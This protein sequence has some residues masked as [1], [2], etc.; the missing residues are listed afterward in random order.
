[1]SKNEEEEYS[2]Q[3]EVVEE[4]QEAIAAAFEQPR[5]LKSEESAN[6]YKQKADQYYDQLLRLQAEFANYR[7]RIEKEKVEAI[8]F[9]KEM[10]VERMISLMDVMEE[11]LKHSQNA[12]AI[13]SLKKGFEMV[14][15]EFLRFL[16]SEGA[17]PLQTVGELFDPHKHEAVE[18]LETETE[19]E[20]N[21]VLEEIQKGYSLN[22]RLLRPAKVKVAKFKKSDAKEDQRSG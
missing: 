18:Q 22:G 11:A 8:R 14:V 21:I 17:E 2:K 16:K 12:A 3:R 20:N 10:M 6:A 4:E 19:A 7:K 9:G 5:E 15:N 13:H 1:M